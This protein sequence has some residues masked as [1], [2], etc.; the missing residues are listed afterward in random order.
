[1]KKLLIA[2]AALMSVAAPAGAVTVVLEG[3]TAEGDNTRFNYGG[4]FALNPGGAPLEGLLPGS[5]LVIFDFLGYVP[6]SVSSPYADVAATVEWTS[7]ADLLPP[8]SFD[9]PGIANLVFTWT[10]A[11][12]TP[13]AGFA[14]TGLSALSTYS[15]VNLTG[16]AFGSASLKVSNGTPLYVLGFVGS[17][18]V[19]EP[20][21]WGMMLMGFGL[22]G[23]AL[24]SRRRG[25]RVVTA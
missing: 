19:P 5:Q 6:G 2:A 9:D 12:F 21:V 18:A 25:V 8:G 16:S 20:A 4:S 24:R 11:A 3:T 22:V 7:N 23:T 17:P 13:P 10:G 1:M 15:G 14:Y